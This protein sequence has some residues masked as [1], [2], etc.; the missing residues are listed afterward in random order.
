M[1][2]IQQ[3]PRQAGSNGI[4][5]SPHSFDVVDEKSAKT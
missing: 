1:D 5:V 3:F 2:T 4:H